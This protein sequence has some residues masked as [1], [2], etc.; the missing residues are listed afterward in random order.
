MLD[1][2]NSLLSLNANILLLT[3]TSYIL[4]TDLVTSLKVK[5]Y[6]RAYQDWKW[7]SVLTA[8]TLDF[9]ALELD[10]LFYNIFQRHDFSRSWNSLSFLLGLGRV[11]ENPTR[12]CHYLT[13]PEKEILVSGKTR[14]DL[15]PDTKPAGTRLWKKYTMSTTISQEI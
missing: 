6:F 11:P 7:I 3:S 15:K 13:R 14:P 9:T 2:K 1:L 5:E 8:S 12:N 4:K 10:N